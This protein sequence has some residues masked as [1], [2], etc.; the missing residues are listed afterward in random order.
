[1]ATRDYP[2]RGAYL[3]LDGYAGR[4]EQP[5]IVVGETPKKFRIE[6]VGRTKL[7]GR[8][9]WIAAG[10]EALVPKTAIKEIA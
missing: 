3:C 8:N 7:G 9:L 6:A 10:Q 1:M 4:T 5:V 2:R